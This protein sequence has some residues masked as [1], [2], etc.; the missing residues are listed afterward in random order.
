MSQVTKIDCVFCTPSAGDLHGIRRPIAGGITSEELG[1]LV[2]HIIAGHTPAIAAATVA[3]EAADDVARSALKIA[4]TAIKMF[5][6][7]EN[8]VVPK[9][10]GYLRTGEPLQKT[11]DPTGANPV[12]Q[13]TISQGTV[14]GYKASLE[15]E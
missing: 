15:G 5:S 7:S 13:G 10:M 6:S 8:L 11:T 4:N 12:P 14:D 1:K 9:N 3:A 2:Q